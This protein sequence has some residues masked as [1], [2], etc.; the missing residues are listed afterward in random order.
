MSNKS[1]HPLAG[2]KARPEDLFSKE[3]IAEWYYSPQGELE[4][5][6]NGTS[7]HRGHT[8]RGF[9]VLHV[10][11]MSQ[12]L[13]DLRKEKGTFGPHLPEN[14]KEKPLGPV[15]MGKDVRYASDLAQETAAEVFAGNGMKVLIHKGNRSTP[16]PVV[17]HTILNRVMQGEK[18]EGV[19]I[20]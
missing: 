7:G 19:I 17:S 1:L 20:T 3:Q 16:T 10:A 15:I 13:I 14:L 12:A 4:P 11:A 9:S 5:V 2:Q 6:K 18:V 8:G